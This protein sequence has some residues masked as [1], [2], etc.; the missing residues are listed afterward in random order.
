M[1]KLI[2]LFLALTIPICLLAGCGKAAGT[3]Q[4]QPTETQTA[5]FTPVTVENY[6]RTLTIKS[7]PKAVVTAGPNCTEVMCALGLSN[8]VV[9]DSV[10]NH[11]RGPLDQWAS[12]YKAIKEINNGYPTLEAV[13]ASG[14]DFLYA[15]DW[16]FEGD[17]TIEALEQYGITVYVS[18]A[19]DY[20]GVWKELTDLGSIFGVQDTAAQ[21]IASEKDRIAAVE[22]TV[23]GQAPQKVFVFD[24]DCGDGTVYTAGKPNIETTFIQTAGGTNVFGETDDAWFA[25]SYEEILK[26]NPDVIVVHDYF[27]A[28][29]ENN[30]EAM[31]K[32]PILSQLDAVKNNRFIKLSLESAFP[33]SRSA[34]TVELLAKGM[35][36][37]LFAK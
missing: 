14:C 22:E 9:G 11:S 21:F 37:D 4:A 24:S 28:S 16:V 30:I 12:D 6:G 8:L 25:V 1:K 10:N 32:S 29:Y 33:G 7:R 13:V 26:A 31:K 18:E 17:F 19:K 36:P 20:D 23:K 27:D 35:H 2:A 15:I 34:Y 3:E 5:A